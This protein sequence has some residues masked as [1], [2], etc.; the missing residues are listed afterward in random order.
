MP[1]NGSGTYTLPESPFVTGTTIDPSPVNNDFNDIAQALTGS[2]AA[3][4]QT[5]MTG[6]L[7]LNGNGIT[8]LSTL[9]A[10]TLTVSGNGTI[11]GTTHLVGKATM[12]GDAAVGGALTVTGLS[13]LGAGVVSSNGVFSGTVEAIDG[14]AG[15][16]VVNYSQF[17]DGGGAADSYLAIPSGWYFQ[18]GYASTG[19][20]GTA[21]VTFPT[22]FSTVCRSFVATP[23][24]V[25]GVAPVIY[26]DGLPSTSQ[27][28][29]ITVDI[30]GTLRATDFY[31][32]AIGR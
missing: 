11:N 21:T 28:S 10:T 5:P 13:T 30:N 27:A 9:D 12:D 16:Q 22:T 32:M 24:W 20:G 3:D 14:T 26:Q 7:D 17:P 19:G 6:D 2:V 8:G 31:W 4:G 1:R 25:S 15:N 18:C 23:V 29:V